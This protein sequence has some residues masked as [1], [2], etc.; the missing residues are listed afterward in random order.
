MKL[1][2]LFTPIFAAALAVATLATPASAQAQPNEAISQNSFQ[3]IRNATAKIHYAGKTFLL[4]PMLAKKGA[5][6]GFE[7]T[8]NSQLRNPL[9]ELPIRAEDV[10]KGVD[11]V[12]VTHTHLDHWD[13][14]A[15]Q[16]LPKNLPIIV[17]NQSDADTIRSQGFTDVRILESE[18]NFDGV[19][20][21]KTGGAHGTVEMY[22]IPQLAGLLGDAMGVVLQADGQ[23]TLYIAGD[24]LWTADVNKAI[25][26]YQPQTVVLNTGY[27]RI[28]GLG[29]GIIMGTADVEHAAKMLPNAK[30][31]AVHMDAVN[32]ATVSRKDLRQFVQEKGIADKVAIP[33]D[34]ETVGF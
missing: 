32:H 30:I 31:I 7:G 12:I 17:Q 20:L 34:G 3:H 23:D 14:A 2:K 21:A 27:A 15:Q 5:Y 25:H 29:G 26:R 4:D 33:N 11:A 16:Q 8:V 22:A 9:I 19:K 10:F 6:A 18:L 13:D 28:E 1:N 24:T